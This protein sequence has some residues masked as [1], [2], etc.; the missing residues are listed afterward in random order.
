MHVN[1]PV[2]LCVAWL[3]MT[4]G[5]VGAL[6]TTHSSTRTTNSLI[7]PLKS[8]Q[9]FVVQYKKSDP[10]VPLIHYAEGMLLLRDIILQILQIHNKALHHAHASAAGCQFDCLP[11]HP[12]IFTWLNAQNLVRTGCYCACN[13][14]CAVCFVDSLPWLTCCLISR[15]CVK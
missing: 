11:V 5:S 2:S 7:P 1:P 9:L 8:V 10:I 4:S 12:S 13:C 14:V 3:W 15:A 6:L